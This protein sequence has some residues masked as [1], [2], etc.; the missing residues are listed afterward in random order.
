MVWLNDAKDEKLT[1]G[2]VV[3]TWFR[4]TTSYDAVV[5]LW[6]MSQGTVAHFDV[7]LF[8]ECNFAQEHDSNVVV[9]AP[10]RVNCTHTYQVFILCCIYGTG[11]ENHT[12]Y[13][14]GESLTDRRDPTVSDCKRLQ[15]SKSHFLN[16]YFSYFV[17]F[18]VASLDQLLVGLAPGLADLNH[19]DFNHD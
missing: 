5:T 15:L 1:V 8:A 3:L 14:N 19:G 2:G 6:C 13:R 9:L 11:K 4:V 7:V 10:R 16:T 18:R 17:D 12:I